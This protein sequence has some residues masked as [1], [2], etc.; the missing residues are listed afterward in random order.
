MKTEQRDLAAIKAGSSRDD[1]KSGSSQS[2]ISQNIKTEHE[3][4]PE[5]KMSQVEAIAYSKARE[6]K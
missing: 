5:M 1:L 4:H 2:V 6:S 3:A